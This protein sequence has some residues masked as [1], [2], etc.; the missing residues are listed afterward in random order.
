MTPNHSHRPPNQ[1]A[2]DSAPEVGAGVAP[3]GAGALERLASRAGIELEYVNARNERVEASAGA[4][5]AALA[6][7]GIPVA[8][9]AEAEEHLRALAR[10]EFQRMLPPVMVLRHDDLPLVVP[11]NPPEGMSAIGWRL[12]LESGDSRSGTVETADLAFGPASAAS[13]TPP[14]LLTIEGPIP[15]GYHSLR[16]DDATMPLIVTPSRCWQPPVLAG[17][18]RVWGI[19]SQL[20]LLRSDHDW[21]IGDYTD[22]RELIDLAT[23]WGADVIGLNP[24]HALFPDSPGMCSPYAP[25]SRLFL[26]ILNIDVASAPGFAE[27]VEVQRMVNSEEFQRTLAAARD[28][29]QVETEKAAELKLGA[30]RLLFREFKRTATSHDRGA[31]NDFRQSRG[32]ALERYALFQALRFD[33]AATDSAHLDWR[34]WPEA[35]RDPNSYL[36]RAYADAHQDDIEFISWTQWVADVQLHHA[37]VHARMRGMAIGLYRDLAIGSDGS[38]AENW[39]NPGTLAAKAHAGAPPDL[40]N[41]AGQDW[42]LPPFN[43]LKLRAEGY[44]SFVELL[45][46]NMRYAGGLRIDHVAGLRHLY[47]V[48]EGNSAADGVYV[49]YPFQDLLNIL[50]LESVRHQCLVIGEDLGTVPEGLREALTAANVLSCRVLYFEQ[51]AQ[52]AFTPPHQYPSLALASV[53]THDLPTLRGWWQGRDIAIHQELGLYPE[54][55]EAERQGAWRTTDKDSL[56]AALRAE[57]LINRDLTGTDDLEALAVA[58]HAFLARS[59]SAITMV[60]LDDLM[61]EE[62]QVNLPATTTEY[63]NWRRRHALTLNEFA[64]ASNALSIVDA[65]R[66]ARLVPLSSEAAASNRRM[67]TMD[68]F[69]GS[70]DEIRRRAREHIEKGAVTDEYHADRAKVVEILNRILAIELVCVLRYK[71]HFYSVRGINSENAKKEFGEHALEAQQHSDMVA[72]RI[73]ELNGEPNF[74]PDG[75]AARSPSQYSEPSGIYDMIRE[76]LVAERVAIEFYTEFVRWIGNDDLTTRKMMIEILAV[77]E[78]HADDMKKLMAHHR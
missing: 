6:A 10:E 15:E 8:T 3:P 24:L 59:N 58:V 14:R 29:H 40:Y 66:Q 67:H 62:T 2:Q 74:N 23:R 28:A 35:L 77:E 54:A 37:A 48:P 69:T 38:G 25:S 31:F 27:A 56:L 34:Q 36:S 43:P 46:A 64:I 20:N 39:C 42:G 5:K 30:L 21:G 50:A 51:D 26:N 75:L 60:Q 49:N 53:S 17:G 52:R 68:D 47:W 57:G 63:P 22:L 16:I 71:R 45:R 18:R 78:Q 61:G 73:V 70:S 55:T 4:I 19:A 32:E 41:P 72:K 9:D 76:D 33:R 44:R 12:L 65:V 13:M 7:L 1:P 11:I